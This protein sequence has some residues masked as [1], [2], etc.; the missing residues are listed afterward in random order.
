MI[1]FLT[2]D[3]EEEIFSEDEGDIQV[4]LFFSGIKQIWHHEFDRLLLVWWNHARLIKL[5]PISFKRK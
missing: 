1:F 2:T 5:I 4:L 3:S